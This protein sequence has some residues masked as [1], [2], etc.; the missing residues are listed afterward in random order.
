VNLFFLDLRARGC[1]VNKAPTELV[2]LAS[3]RLNRLHPG[4]ISLHLFCSR[5]HNYVLCNVMKCWS[6]LLFLV[7]PALFLLLF[8]NLAINLR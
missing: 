6:V 5:K 7:Q 3:A 1:M 2:K 4:N 8:A